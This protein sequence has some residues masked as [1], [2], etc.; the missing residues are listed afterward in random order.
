M[1]ISPVAYTYTADRRVLQISRPACAH[2]LAMN[3]AGV[4]RAFG[5]WNGKDSS[6]TVRSCRRMRLPPAEAFR[7]GTAMMLI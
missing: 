7:L 3:V 5:E 1:R 6:R 2:F 4:P